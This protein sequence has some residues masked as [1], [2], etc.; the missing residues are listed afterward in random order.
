[1]FP[2]YFPQ[3]TSLCFLIFHKQ[4]LLTKRLALNSCVKFTPYNVIRLSYLVRYWWYICLSSHFNKYS[5]S[6]E[7][8]FSV[9][10]ITIKNLLLNVSPGLRVSRLETGPTTMLG[11]FVTERE[12]QREYWTHL[13]FEYLQFTNN[14]KWRSTKKKHR[15]I[16]SRN[17]IMNYWSTLFTIVLES[18]Y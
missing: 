6:T 11:H 7:S 14:D 15:K 1:M 8:S 2:L 12:H 17:L 9:L 4:I 3:M 16:F 13:S 5:L 10:T 18:H